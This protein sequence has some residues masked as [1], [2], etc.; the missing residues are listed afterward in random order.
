[1]SMIGFMFALAIGVWVFSVTFNAT[2]KPKKP[3]PP[4]TNIPGVWASIDRAQR[5]L[6]DSYRV[7][8]GDLTCGS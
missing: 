8:Y 5:T 3:K 6:D 2:H 7:I 1:M 4:P